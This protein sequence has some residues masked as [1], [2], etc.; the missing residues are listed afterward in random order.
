MTFRDPEKKFWPQ[1]INEHTAPLI[2]VNAIEEHL[3][4]EALDS[5][6]AA[7]NEATLKALDDMERLAETLWKLNGRSYR[8]DWSGLAAAIDRSIK[9]KRRWLESMRRYFGL[10]RQSKDSLRKEVYGRQ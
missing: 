10:E 6:M 3:G 8:S 5:E 1:E 9:A 7:D 4:G 2:I